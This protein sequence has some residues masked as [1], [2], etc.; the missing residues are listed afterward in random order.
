[1][2]DPTVPTP[3]DPVA[4]DSAPVVPPPRAQRRLN[5]TFV[6]SAMCM[7]F[8]VF[9]LNGS[10]DFSPLPAHNLLVLIGVLNAYEITTLAF[11]LLLH[12]R[13]LAIDARTLIVIEALFL[14]DGA[15]LTSEL[16]TVMP[17]VGR[18]IAAALL[19]AG[20]L[21]LW[22]VLQ[23]A[24]TRLMSR[25]G[26]MALI[27]MVILPLIPSTLKSVADAHAG[28]LT[29]LGYYAGWWI[30]S[31]VF[32]A[33][34]ALWRREDG[35]MVHAIVAI[36]IVSVVAH[37][38]TDGWVNKVTFAAADVAPVV[39]GLGLLVGQASL[40]AL[41]RDTAA[42]LQLLL[43]ILA[44][45]LCVRTPIDMSFDVAGVTISPLRLTLL[46]AVLIYVHGLIRHRDPLFGIALIGGTLLAGA[47][48][49]TRAIG[50][51]ATDVMHMIGDI[52]RRM[53]PRTLAQWG[54]IAVVSAFALMIGGALSSLRREKV[55]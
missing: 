50:M 47:G 45:A 43:P 18:P 53:I 19:L 23:V 7:I 17:A 42:R 40:L 49:T 32:V 30:A 39:L 51:T 6:L 14:F 29:P 13:G 15:F 33:A 9:A 41:P 5:A 3:L 36:G 55:D 10:L 21:K 26:A 35:A 44:A 25:T 46:A 1:M 54:W 28:V 2:S 11:A 31:A 38:A 37:I 20:V 8:G 12:R 22:V 4:A 48:A 27:T 16:I 52:V 24:G 34:A